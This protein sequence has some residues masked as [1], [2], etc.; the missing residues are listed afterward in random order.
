MSQTQLRGYVFALIS[1][2]GYSA[3]SVIAKKGLL[4]Y[5]SPI[6]AVC[7]S[8]LTGTLIM[9]LFNFRNVE[10]NPAK[11]RKGL[12]FFALSGIMAG[13]GQLSSYL[14]LGLAPVV[15]VSPL[16]NTTPLFTV[17]L[18]PIFL[19]GLEKVSLRVAL[20]AGL[21]VAGVVLISLGRA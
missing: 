8:L 14:A 4:T 20:A 3:V 7:V 17:F 16:S 12:L 18:V 15:I 1:A 19:R 13:V 6:A 11:G 10:I 5:G 21:I 2:L 9:A